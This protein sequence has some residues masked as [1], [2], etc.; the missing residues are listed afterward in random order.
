MWISLFTVVFTIALG[1]GMGAI[2]L[3]G[4]EGKSTR[5]YARRSARN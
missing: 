3:D 1:L 4:T 2:L 5:R